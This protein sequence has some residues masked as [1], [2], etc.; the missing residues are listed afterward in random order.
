M[1]CPA[2]M[3]SEHNSK[4]AATYSQSITFPIKQ[5]FLIVDCEPFECELFQEVQWRVSRV[6]V[7]F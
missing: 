3:Y 5:W 1:L 4:T 6:P 7:L 2:V